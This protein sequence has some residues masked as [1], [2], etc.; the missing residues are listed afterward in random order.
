METIIQTN[1]RTLQALLKVKVACTVAA[2]VVLI[3]RFARLI[4]TT[5]S[6]SM[7]VTLISGA[8]SAAPALPNLE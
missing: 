7:A 5:T 4:A 2:I 6:F 8:S 3:R 1:Y